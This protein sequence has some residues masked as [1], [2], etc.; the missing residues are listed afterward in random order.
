MGSKQFW[1]FVRKGFAVI[2]I[3]LILAN[4]VW[5]A[6]KEKLLFSFAGGNDGGDPAAGLIFDKAGN[7]Y[8]TTIFGGTGTA[9]AGQHSGCGTVFKLTRNSRGEWKETVIYNFQAGADGKNP[10]GGL[11]MNSKGVLFGSTVAGGV[12]GGC[13][14]GDGCGTIFELRRSGNNWTESVLYRFTGNKDGFGPGGGV[15]FDKKGNLYGTAADGGKPNGCAGQGCG[16]VYQLAPTKGGGWR[17]KA[18]HTFTGGS[19]GARGSLGLLH[20]D[21]SGNLYGAAEV[22]G[23]ATCGCGTI[24][25]LS[26]TSAGRWKFSTLHA[27][28]GAPDGYSSYGGLIADGAGSLYGTTYFGGANGQGSVFQLTRGS[29]GRW[30]NTILY[31]FQGST[32]GGN[33]TST[34]VFDAKGNLYGTTTAAGDS[35]GDGVVF[36][37]SHGS[38]GWTESVV[39][40]FGPSPDGSQPYYGLVRHAGKLYSTTSIGG[41]GG[42]GVVFELTP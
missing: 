9:C 5:A 16:V 2:S 22:G 41:R 26:A 38:G 11:T 8:G 21:K 35:N 19:D 20:F 7:V 18:I 42:Q 36:K 39:H 3:T 4:G 1:C 37:L 13:P 31:S 24:F 25:K 15:V 28:T 29:N 12:V 23:D 6:S 33:P 27:F 30:T 40:N 17:Q 34:L 10:Y 14:N 32:D